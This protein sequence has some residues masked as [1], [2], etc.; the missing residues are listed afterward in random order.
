MT[1]KTEPFTTGQVNPLALAEALALAGYDSK[2][3]RWQDPRTALVVN[4]PGW[5][6]RPLPGRNGS[7]QR[8]AAPQRRPD[9]SPADRRAARIWAMAQGLPVADRGRLA[10]EVIDR[11][12]AAGRPS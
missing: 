6:P 9:T 8:A 11:W 2:R 4:F 12:H 7:R 3:I 10:D 5:Q 1:G